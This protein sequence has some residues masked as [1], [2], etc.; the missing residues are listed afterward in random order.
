[1]FKS[2]GR[3][4]ATLALV[5]AL[6][7]CGG[8][9]S[10]VSGLIP[11]HALGGTVSGLQTQ[12]L[13]LATN[14]QSLAVLAGSTSFTFP[15]PLADGADFSVTVAQQSSGETCAVGGG[16]GKIGGGPVRFV[17]VVCV[18]KTFP[19]SV[20][21][22]G[23]SRPGL[24]LSFAGESY[25]IPSS[26]FV[27]PRRLPLGVPYSITVAQQ[28]ESDPGHLFVPAS[29]RCS[30][31]GGT[32]IVT[33]E[34]VVTVVCEAVFSFTVD[35]NGLTGS[36]LVIA[37]GRGDV[38]AIEPT[39]TGRPPPVFPQLYPFRASYT[40][41]IL[42]QPAG[43]SCTILNPSGLFLPVRFVEVGPVPAFLQV[44][45]SAS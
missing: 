11:A 30:V 4:I 28:P 39:G 45:C 10:E 7:G 37:L 38:L 6:A 27:F 9:G 18:P 42:Q 13:V 15:V 33:G 32:G 8:G 36:G 1:M 21:I 43:N 44:R 25:A 22:S 34:T 40:A 24:Q 20:V 35:L 41:S 16:D 19:V 12:G 2:P 23:P 29:Y 17:I 26:G 31:P 5:S 14:G 3:V